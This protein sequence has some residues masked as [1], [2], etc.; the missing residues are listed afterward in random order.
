MRT[1][2]LIGKNLI[3]S[4]SKQYFS[5]KFIKKKITN[6]Q[7]LHFELENISEFKGLIKKTKIHGLNVTI[8][9]KKSIIPFLDELS[10]EASL[11]GAVNTIHF[12]KGKLIG[13]NT[14]YIGFK[15]SIQPLLKGRNKALVLGNGGASKAI[16]YALI[17]LGIKF[18]IISRNTSFDY[19]DIIKQT[20]EYYSIIINTTPLGSYPK[21][22]QQPNIPYK[23]LNKNNLLFDVIYNP[24]ET[25]FLAYGRARNTQTKNGVEML[26]IQAEESWKIWNQ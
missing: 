18:K 24:N 1:F 22:D 14:D 4:F 12:N 5:E 8:P 13:Y 20:T 10:E 21:I 3:H 16:Q 7:Y 9:Y 11:I 17:Q 26:K 6:T 2:G 25:K 15:K 23:Y 19:S